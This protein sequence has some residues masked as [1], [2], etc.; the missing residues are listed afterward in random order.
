MVGYIHEYNN[1]GF[2]MLQEIDFKNKKRV[3]IKIGSNS[4]LHKDT[5]KIDYLKI[6]K[7]RN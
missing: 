2:F 7:L 4:L 6:E 5:A 1:K 3:V